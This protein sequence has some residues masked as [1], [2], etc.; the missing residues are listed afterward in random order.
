MPFSAIPAVKMLETKV[1]RS[2]IEYGQPKTGKTYDFDNPYLSVGVIDLD[3]TA[4]AVLGG[5][6]NVTVYRQENGMPIDKV[7]DYWDLKEQ[8]ANGTLKHDLWVVDSWTRLSE[9]FKEYVATEYVPN[10]KRELQGRFGAMSD[11]GDWQ[12]M[13]VFEAKHW[14]AMTKDPRLA[15]TVVHIFHADKDVDGM[16]KIMLQ[17]SFGWKSIMSIVDAVFYKYKHVQA[18]AQDPNKQDV[19]YPLVT[20]MFN[21]GD[22]VIN[23]EVRTGKNQTRLPQFISPVNWYEILKTMGAKVPE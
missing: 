22:L 3:G 12:E 16:S 1:G 13:L 8:V 9:M 11:W 18:N 4:E 7:T 19:F 21:Q 15:F 20:Q 6:K 10:R 14:H 5:A 23:A 17:G 2:I